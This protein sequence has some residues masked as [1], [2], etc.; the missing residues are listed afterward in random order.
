MLNPLFANIPPELSSL[1]RWVVWRNKVPFNASAPEMNASSTNPETWSSFDLACT[2]YEEG[3][4]DGVGFVLNGD[5][6]VGVDLDKCVVD[7]KPSDAALNLLD[8]IGC[9]YVELSP[10]GTGLRGFGYGPVIK[11]T[12]GTLDGVNV[13]L[14]STKRYLTVTGH[15][16]K[17]ELIK[18]LTGFTD[19]AESIRSVSASQASDTYRENREYGEN[20]V[21]RENSSHISVLSVL[22]VGD[23]IEK[24]KPAAEGDRNRCLFELARYV[25]AI[26]P[27]A[28]QS[29]LRQIAMQWHEVALPVIG[30]KDPLVTWCDFM[31]GFS[32][33]RYPAGTTLTQIVGEIDMSV[34]IPD[35]LVALGY[36]AKAVHLFRIC[37]RLQEQAGDETFFISSRQAGELIQMH[38]TDVAKMLASFCMDGV[39]QEIQKG[40]GN[41]ATRYRFIWSE[42]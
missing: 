25:K 17:D 37:Q 42:K 11:G 28:S 9:G 23:A 39:L 31:R 41:R 35:G 1:N 14:Y 3:G 18:P 27:N 4:F 32:S 36:R 34:P 6:L 33:V 38:F 8:R 30:T 21:N 29:E 16:L 26:R 5:G 13:E 15:L 22:S 40:V 24:T 19:V 12:S 2:T 10:S 7:G 20:R